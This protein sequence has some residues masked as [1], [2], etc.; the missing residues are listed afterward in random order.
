MS[1]SARCNR[2]AG[3]RPCKPSRMPL[4]RRPKKRGSRF[5]RSCVGKRTDDTSHSHWKRP[6]GAGL[7]HLKSMIYMSASEVLADSRRYESSMFQ[8][9]TKIELRSPVRVRNSAFISQAQ[10]QGAGTSCRRRSN[11]QSRSRGSAFI[12]VCRT[13]SSCA[14]RRRNTEYGFAGWTWTQ[15]MQ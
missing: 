3:S 11:Q 13:A 14:Q 7:F 10:R 9:V 5:L 15:A 4:S 8:H 1:Q 2:F 6:A 12:L